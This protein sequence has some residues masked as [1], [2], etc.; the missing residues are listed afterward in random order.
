MLYYVDCFVGN[1]LDDDEN[2]RACMGHYYSET[3]VVNR[4]I[5]ND[6]H[7]VSKKRPPFYFSNNSVK[8]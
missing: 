1:K 4:Y 6:I 3:W 5:L 8:S 2:C 7:C